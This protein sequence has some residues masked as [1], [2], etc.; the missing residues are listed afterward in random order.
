M[1]Q[2]IQESFFIPDEIVQGTLD[3]LYERFGGII[4]YAKGSKKGEIFKHLQPVDTKAE[5]T[6]KELQP[7]VIGLA[8]AHPVAT[9]TILAVSA[10]VSALAISGVAFWVKEIRI[11]REIKNFRKKLTDY[12]EAIRNGHLTTEQ[13]DSLLLS[14]EKL[15]LRKDFNEI[16]IQL[17]VSQMFEL[18]QCLNKYTNNLIRNN[19]VAIDEIEYCSTTS[20]NTVICLEKYLT[21]Q[22]KVFESAA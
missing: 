1:G 19:A 8:N 18:I 5:E 20:D 4:R 3:G 10:V 13:I 11:P 14:I 2:I 15:K 21:I 12:I 22:K 16:S 17:S 6:T 9:I 7:N